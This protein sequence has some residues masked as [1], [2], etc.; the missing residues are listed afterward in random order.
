MDYD[1]TLAQL[2][3]MVAAA[4]EPTLGEREV[5]QLLT[6]AARPDAAG[7]PPTNVAGLGGWATGAHAVGEVI[8]EGARYWRVLVPGTSATTEP[9]WPDLTTSGGAP[10]GTRVVDNGVVW[11]DNGTAWAP[12]WDLNAAAA[13]GWE[14]K[15]SK[16]AGDFDFMTGDQQ[17]MRSQRAAAC[18]EQAR[19]YRAKIVGSAL[20]GRG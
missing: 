4:A 11:I 13:A 8:L 6:G 15:A 1:I 12:T 20:I 17:F 14:R 3:D 18:R 16:A 7:N 10:T 9:T 5:E 2:A 19:A